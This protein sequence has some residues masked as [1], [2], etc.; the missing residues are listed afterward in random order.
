MN[1]ERLREMRKISG[2]TQ[3]EIADALAYDRVHYSDVENGNRPMVD[4][5]YARAISKML[6]RCQDNT[7]ILQDEA[8]RC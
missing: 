3:K 7:R 2:M 1:H 4:G 5:F 8:D 6:K